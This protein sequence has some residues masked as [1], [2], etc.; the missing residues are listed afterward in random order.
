MLS[1]GYLAIKGQITVV[2]RWS[3][4]WQPQRIFVQPWKELADL[5]NQDAGYV[6]GGGN[7]V[8]LKRF[9]GHAERLTQACFEAKPA[10]SLNRCAELYRA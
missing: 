2:A 5:Y 9:C 8:V 4:R 10:K 3:R 7:V 6:A 1:G